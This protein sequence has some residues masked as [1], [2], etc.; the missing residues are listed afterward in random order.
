MAGLDPAIQQ[1]KQGH[2]PPLD[3]RVTPGHDEGIGGNIRAIKLWDD[4]L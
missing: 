4:G 2:R 1:N 3:G